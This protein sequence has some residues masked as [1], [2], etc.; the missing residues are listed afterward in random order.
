MTD[1]AS[2]AI[3]IESLQVQQADSRLK[4]LASSG[5][6]A[7]KATSGLMGAFTKLIGPLTAAVSVMGTSNWR[8]TSTR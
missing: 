2:L 4:G 1:V 5:G 6:S 8:W 3:K 7:E